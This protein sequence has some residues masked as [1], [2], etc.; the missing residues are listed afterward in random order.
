MFA[1]G[2]DPLNR[3]IGSTPILA[4]TIN[5]EVSRKAIENA[6]LAIEAA[7]K[8]CLTIPNGIYHMSAKQDAKG[9]PCITEVNIGRTP[10]T[11]SIF[12]KTGNYNVAEYFLNYALGLEIAD[13]NPIYDIP[14]ETS[15]A[16]RSLDYPLCIRSEKEINSAKKI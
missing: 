4:K 3:G 8:E 2:G 13:P 11:V 6:V 14:N 15:Y 12:N 5:D 10:S 9:Q 16:I 7:S 1:S